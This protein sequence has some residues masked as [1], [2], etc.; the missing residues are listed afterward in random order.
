MQ[1]IQ[2][3]NDKKENKMKI[4]IWSDIMCPFCYIGKRKFETALAQF[5]YKGKIQVEW[6]SFQL[7]PELKTQPGRS[8]NQFLAEEKGMP[9][10]RAKAM[11]DQVVQ[12]AKQ[13]G[14][15]YEFDKT[16]PANTFKAHQFTHFAKANG[17]QDEAEETLFH[18]YFIEG[19]NIDELSTLL[20]L[21]KEIGLDA[22]ALKK[23]LE[24]E[25]YAD[26]VRKD[27]HEA[28]QVD[29]RGVPFFVFNRKSAIS[30]AQESG[31]FLEVLDKTFAD[32]RKDNPENALEVISGPSCT[33]NGKCD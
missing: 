27:I 4:E 10:E 33:P 1:I 29:V 24:N 11:N 25:S 16:I 19:R 31:T 21:G 14:L 13:I 22:E 8:L 5:P 17:K 18:A 20:A 23:A 3:I 28:Q 30:G 7:M 26:A 9:L 32:W 6:K 2:S 15:N 12:I